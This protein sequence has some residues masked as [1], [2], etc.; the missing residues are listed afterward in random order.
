MEKSIA[1]WHNQLVKHPVYGHIADLDSLRIFMRQ[2]IFAVWDF[3]SLLK[4]LQRHLTCVDVPWM[5]SPYSGT[6]V[7]MIN[8]IVLGEESDLD[9]DGNPNSH[10]AMYLEAM[11]EVGATRLEINDFLTARDLEQLRPAVRNF[12][13]H[14]LELAQHGECEEVLGSFLFGREKLLPEVFESIVSVLKNSN[15][16]CPKL[17]YYFERHI[18]LDGDSHG[19]MATAVLTE[20]CGDNLAKKQRA[21]Q[22]GIK[23]LQLRSALWDETLT[24][25]EKKA[26]LA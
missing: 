10:F 11:D 7:R 1:S 6:V 4:A 8:E 20:V 14:H 5:P 16:E 21:Y 26:N 3:M 9:F 22:A 24:L 25:I 13:S 2:H 18:E 23:S 12:V 15:L 19:P 17:R